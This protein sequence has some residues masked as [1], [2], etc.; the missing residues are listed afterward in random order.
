MV[1]NAEAEWRVEGMDGNCIAH[2]SW[3]DLLRK[4]PNLI[5][6][7]YFYKISTKIIFP[8]VVL[9]SC[10]VEGS[11]QAGKEKLKHNVGLLKENWIW[12]DWR[13]STHCIAW[14]DLPSLLSWISLKVCRFVLT[15]YSEL[16]MKF[17]KINLEPVTP[18]ARSNFY[19]HSVPQECLKCSGGFYP[20]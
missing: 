6:I 19:F 12:K 7:K 4:Q 16:Y 3:S 17:I 15:C 1:K 8:K 2:S 10:L 13:P 14:P 9:Q 5:Y 11:K 18:M 20:T